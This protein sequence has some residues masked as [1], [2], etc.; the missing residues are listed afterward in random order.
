MI[1]ARSKIVSDTDN[2]EVEIAFTMTVHQWDAL[3][4]NIDVGK[5]PNGDF[6]RVMRRALEK[7][8]FFISASDEE[9]IES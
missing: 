9:V 5:W 6:T 3:R 8:K 2:I 1:T 4:E 7:V